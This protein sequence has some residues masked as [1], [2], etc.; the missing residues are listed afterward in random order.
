MDP[1]EEGIQAQLGAPADL[2]LGGIRLVSQY[3]TLDSTWSA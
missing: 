1:L 2:S 3:C